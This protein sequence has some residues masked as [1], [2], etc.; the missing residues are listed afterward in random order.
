MKLICTPNWTIVSKMVFTDLDL[1][2]NIAIFNLSAPI[3][4]DNI[5][6]L[7]ELIPPLDIIQRSQYDDEKIF[8]LLYADYILN[9]DLVFAQMFNIVYKL[10]EGEDVCVL[11][12][13]ENHLCCT[14][15]D[16]L[17]KFIQQRYGWNG[18]I[19]RTGGDYE[20]AEDGDFTLNGIKTF[21]E[22]KERWVSIM[23]R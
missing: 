2:N 3:D 22:D 8:D 16:S 20:V 12:S 13:E 10:Y 1:E 23:A 18:N 19:V 15:T 14:I 4:G 6:K 5:V 7:N 17:L 9:N 21:D 11:I